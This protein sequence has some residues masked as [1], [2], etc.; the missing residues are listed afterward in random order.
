[1]AARLTLLAD[2][3]S[4]ARHGDSDFAAAFAG[5]RRAIELDRYGIAAHVLAI[6]DGCTAERCSIFALLDDTD[7][8][9]SNLKAQVF[10]QYVSR[11]A[12]DWNKASPKRRRGREAAAG[13][14]AGR[15]RVASAEHRPS[16]ARA[17]TISPRP[18][19]SRRSAS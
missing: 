14:G 18:T 11:Y 8:L 3:L 19:R 10:D 5:L 1:M 9:K 17:T 13:V 16:G 6:R 12:A 4:F 7:V 2:G 15:Q